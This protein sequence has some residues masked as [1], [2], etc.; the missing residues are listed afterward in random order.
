MY[1]GPSSPTLTISQTNC[2]IL[3]ASL[4]WIATLWLQSS[5]PI[6]RRINACNHRTLLHYNNNNKT[7]DHFNC[8]ARLKTPERSPIADH[9]FQ[10]KQWQQWH[11]TGNACFW[12]TNERQTR[13]CNGRT[14]VAARRRNDGL[15][16]VVCICFPAYRRYACLLC[17]FNFA[18]KIP[19]WRYRSPKIP[20][21]T[22][23][24]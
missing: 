13:E 16:P 18:L 21:R 19:Q 9:H 8:Y 6:N 24:K 15:S 23:R 10:Q 4:Q 7:N 5:T 20:W 3:M 22:G 14:N 12:M 2:C 1:L 11:H 17:A